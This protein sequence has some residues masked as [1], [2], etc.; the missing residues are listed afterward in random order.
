MTNFKTELRFTKVIK[1]YII[2]LDPLCLK[3]IK[4]SKKLI[5]KA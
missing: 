3:I 2:T 5:K 1:N 4:K